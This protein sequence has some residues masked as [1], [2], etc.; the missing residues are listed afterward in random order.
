MA[1]R[2]LIVS[3]ISLGCLF[4]ADPPKP[5]APVPLTDKEE[6]DLWRAQAELSA[7]NAQATTAESQ[8]RNALQASQEKLAAWN[9][10]LEA[11]K[12]AHHCEDCDLQQNATTRDLELKA[13]PPAPKADG[14]DKKP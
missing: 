12:K 5:P 9:A 14:P 1:M 10:A 7:A 11:V 13:K 6:K 3:L 8:Y 2:F 4:A